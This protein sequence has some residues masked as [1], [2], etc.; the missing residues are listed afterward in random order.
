MPRIIVD[1]SYLKGSGRDAMRNDL[2]GYTVLI[3]FE[4]IYEIMTNSD[5]HNP[6][7]YLDRLVGL[8][9][10]LSRSL[11]GLV[12]TE[13]KQSHRI[14]NV[15]HPDSERLLEFVNGGQSIGVIPD[16]AQEVEESFEKNEPRRLR[17]GLDRMWEEKHADIFTNFGSNNS[18]VTTDARK[19][20]ELFAPLG[21]Q[22]I[23][24]QHGMKQSPTPG[25]LIYEWE[26]LR[27]FLAFRF[28]L[29]GNRS[30]HLSN[31]KTLANSLVDLTYLAFLSHIDAIAT[32]E[33][34]VAALAEVFGPANLKVIQGSQTIAAQVA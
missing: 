25:W 13:I 26:Q 10:V 3:T 24:G 18:D 23:A 8:D 9:L 2:S 11:I 17:E 21:G 30:H 19:Y 7:M 28:R 29:K 14:D 16:V 33:K 32:N 12:N 20:L 34:S 22:A 5:K 15:L 6:R 1:F 31:D 27:N 4:L